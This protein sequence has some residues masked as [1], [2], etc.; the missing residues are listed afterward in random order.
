ME[1]FLTEIKRKT[2]TAPGTD[3]KCESSQP[4]VN[5]KYLNNYL[6]LAFKVN[7]VGDEERAF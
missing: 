5:L 6:E 7:G 1:I 2:A 3:G 4:Q